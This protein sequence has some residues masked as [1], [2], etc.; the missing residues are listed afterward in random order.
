MTKPSTEFQ[1]F[2]KAIDK[3]MSVSPEELKRRIAAAKKA[4][5]GKRYPK[6]QEDLKNTNG[7]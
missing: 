7:K 4:K 3:I 5:K 1:K 2:D 6:P